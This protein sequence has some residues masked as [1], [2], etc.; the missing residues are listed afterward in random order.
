MDS[1]FKDTLSKATSAARD[2]GK[3]LSLGEEGG[4]GGSSG[5]TAGGGSTTASVRRPSLDEKSQ[6]ELAVLCKQQ[7][8]RLHR[9]EEEYKKVRSKL[10]GET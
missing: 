4:G 10:Q 3:T 8:V 9:L 5:S 1:F 7:Q 6:A 2:F